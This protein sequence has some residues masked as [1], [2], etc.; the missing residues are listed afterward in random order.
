MAQ[1]QADSKNAKNKTSDAFEQ[2]TEGVRSAFD[3]G[4]QFHQDA[5]Q[6]WFDAFGGNRNGSDQRDGVER[7]ATESIDLTR[8]NADE[9]HG[10]FNSTCQVGFDAI[11]KSF[12]AVSNGHDKDADAFEQCRSAWKNG[13]D[14][15]CSTLQSAGKANVRMIENWASFLDRA[16]RPVGAKDAAN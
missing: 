9:A 4:I 5:L 16:C 14:A 1:N 13:A 3:T 15:V 11:K 10:V 2:A 6:T 7:F 8:K 12:E